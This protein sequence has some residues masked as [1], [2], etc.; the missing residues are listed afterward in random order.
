MA[1]IPAGRK[2]GPKADD[3]EPLE[4]QLTVVFRFGDE[5]G[6]TVTMIDNRSIPMVDNLFD[7]RDMIV[8]NFVKLLL[9]AGVTQPKVI[10]ELVPALKLVPRRSKARA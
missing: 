10:R 5:P 1:I 9:K 8:R 2:R 4:V 3:D 6:D 7:S